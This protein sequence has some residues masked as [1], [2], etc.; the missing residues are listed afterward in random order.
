MELSQS[1][2]L[3]SNLGATILEEET[4][5]LWPA[6]WGYGRLEQP[7][8]VLSVRRKRFYFRKA[9]TAIFETGASGYSVGIAGSGL[10]TANDL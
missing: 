2:L 4:K 10:L 8:R 1:L 3:P 5:K 9:K 7:N 6:D